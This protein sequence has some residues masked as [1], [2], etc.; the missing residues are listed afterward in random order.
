MSGV[1]RGI[2]KAR[3]ALVLR[4]PAVTQRASIFTRPP[5]DALGPVETGV[6]LAMFSL[7]ILGPPGW[8]LANLESYKK[9]E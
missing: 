8:I 4:G 7:A 5:K 3:S 1:L 9:K 2:A 6:G